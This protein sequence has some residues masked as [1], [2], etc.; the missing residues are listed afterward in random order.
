[1]CVRFDLMR[2]CGVNR[3]ALALVARAPAGDGALLSMWRAVQVGGANKTK[4]KNRSRLIISCDF[5]SVCPGQG[6]IHANRYKW[7]NFILFH[8]YLYYIIL[9]FKRMDIYFSCFRHF[10]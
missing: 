5:I 7:L 4:M 3:Y 8:N 6:P 1:M 10:S 2:P 9:E